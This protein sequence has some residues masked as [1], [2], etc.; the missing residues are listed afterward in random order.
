M[1]LFAM[2]SMA[3]FLVPCWSAR[4]TWLW[5]DHGCCWPPGCRV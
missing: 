5:D 1:M 2:T 3:V 4:W